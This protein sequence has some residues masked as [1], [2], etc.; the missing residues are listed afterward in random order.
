MDEKKRRLLGEAK[1][2]KSEGIDGKWE[3]RSVYCSFYQIY[4]T[5]FRP[6]EENKEIVRK[7]SKHIFYGA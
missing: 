7:V 4:I 5:W 2:Y 1:P 6:Q 3:R